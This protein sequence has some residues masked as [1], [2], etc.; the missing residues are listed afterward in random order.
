M[1]PYSDM[2]MKEVEQER[3]YPTQLWPSSFGS[4]SWSSW[5]Y[6]LSTFWSVSKSVDST[7]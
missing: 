3:I 6:S 7:V 4:S 2:R 5:P 1:T